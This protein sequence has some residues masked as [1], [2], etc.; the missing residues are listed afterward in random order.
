MPP[1]VPINHYFGPQTNK[2][3]PKSYHVIP[4]CSIQATACFKHSNFLKVRLGSPAP[5][6]WFPEGEARQR[7]YSLAADRAAS[8]KVQLRAF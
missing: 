3:E 1:T 8:P 6:H 2:I 7:Q 5:K 4:C